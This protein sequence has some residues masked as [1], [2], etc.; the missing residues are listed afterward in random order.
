MRRSACFGL[1]LLLTTFFPLAALGAEAEKGM[2]LRLDTAVRTA[3]TNNLG[4]MIQKDDVDAAAGA[5]QAAE[6]EFDILATGEAGAAGQEYA[7][8]VSGACSPGKK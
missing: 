6:G 2:K 8:L 7:P 5:R 1:G 4:I 3:L